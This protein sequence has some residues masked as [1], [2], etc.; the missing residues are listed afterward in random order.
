VVA[1]VST[2]GLWAVARL[3]LLP[4]AAW[5]AVF[6]AAYVAPG[7]VLL[8]GAC[9]LWLARGGAGP[10][11]HAGVILGA[12]L[13]A[14]YDYKLDAL[15]AHARVLAFL[16]PFPGF[17]TLGLAL[18]PALLGAPAVPGWLAWNRVLFALLGFGLLLLAARRRARGFPR[19]PLRRP[20]AV[21]TA[22]VATGLAALGCL[23]MLLP[24]VPALAPPVMGAV[25]Q[26]PGPAPAA[27]A[28]TLDVS[29]DAASGRLQ[30]TAVWDLAGG[31][32][33]DVL[34]NAG[35][36]LTAPPGL[37]VTQPAG[38][39]LVPGTAARLY[40][41]QGSGAGALRLGFSGRLL[42]VPSALPYPP[43]PLGQA[44]E[45]AALGRGRAFFDGRGTWYPLV[46]GP[47]LRPAAPSRV[48]LRLRLSGA[49]APWQGVS[50]RRYVGYSLP[51]VIGTS[52]PYRTFTGSGWVLGAASAPP[53]GARA[54]LDTYARAARLLAPLLPGDLPAAGPLRAVVSPLLLH[55]LLSAQVLWL[56]GAEPFCVPPDPVAGG[57]GGAPPDL[58]AATLLLART[59]WQARLELPGGNL[60]LPA[61]AGRAAAAAEL[62]PEAAVTAWRALGKDPAVAAAWESGAALPVLGRLDAAQR[63]RAAALAAGA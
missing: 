24:P 32:A 1:A 60:A 10:R 31:G 44:F 49:G 8:C 5:I 56:P 47:G 43:F 48:T 34:L 51:P 57:C 28:L 18:P 38:P 12:L 46:V 21:R 54:V 37:A 23:A 20:R 55:P 63:T 26:V 62:A 59:A 35:L 4:A 40:R 14:F 41:L 3:P 45:G 19:L 22:T 33:V 27:T 39:G 15:A 58:E 6:S 9:L 52:A 2:L 50:T 7:F 53:P 16:A 42:P 17:L 13:L 29:A 36:R 30:G 25:P 61:Q 11:Y